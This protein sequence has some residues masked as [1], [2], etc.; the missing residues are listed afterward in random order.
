[1][2]SFLYLNWVLTSI[3]T[4]FLRVWKP[5]SSIHVLEGKSERES[6]KKRIS[7][8]GGLGLLQIVLE[9]NTEG[10][11]SE[12]IGPQRGWIVRSYIGWRGEGF[13]GVDCEIRW[14]EG[15]GTEAY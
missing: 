7:A 6:S 9:P 3:E 2:F 1:M 4:F 13:K 5:L 12:D 11:A 14:L 15:E 8:S 10:C